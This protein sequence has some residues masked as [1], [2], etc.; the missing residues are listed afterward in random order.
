MT[1]EIVDPNCF[2]CGSD[3]T[4]RDTDYGNRRFFVCSNEACGEYEISRSAMKRLEGNAQFKQKAMSK[5]RACRDTDKILEII[6]T[7]P[8]LVEA[9]LKP[10]SSGNPA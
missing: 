6:V 5:A 1:T 7:S 4:S 9:T 2:L 3:A 10:R 8:Q